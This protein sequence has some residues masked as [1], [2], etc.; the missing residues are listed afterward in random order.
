MTYDN[1]GGSGR[2]RMIPG[3]PLSPPAADAEARRSGRVEEWKSGRVEEWKSGRVE[4]WRRA[5]RNI[6]EL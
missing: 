5:G 4:E 6:V 1:P 2:A 3:Q